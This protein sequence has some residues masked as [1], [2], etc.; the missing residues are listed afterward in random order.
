[1]FGS[2]EQGGVLLARGHELNSHNASTHIR[3][4]RD[5]DTCMHAAWTPECMCLLYSTFL[6]YSTS[7][8]ERTVLQMV[9]HARG[10]SQER[11][12]RFSVGVLQGGKGLR[13]EYSVLLE[14]TKPMLFGCRSSRALLQGPGQCQAVCND[15]QRYPTSSWG[16]TNKTSW[17][18]PLFLRP[19]A[20]PSRRA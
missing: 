4:R 6:G 1:M 5:E 2:Y 12:I 8:H 20:G 13:H 14:R 9:E 11:R 19:G 3:R 15:Q 17:T 16:S 18:Q 10:I 7:A